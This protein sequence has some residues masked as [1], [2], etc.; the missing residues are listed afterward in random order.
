[1][2]KNH[3]PKPAN[4]PR[5]IALV[6]DD[7]IQLQLWK[8]LLTRQGYIVQDYASATLALKEFVDSSQAPDLIIS[9]LHM[10]VID[11]WRFC[12]LLRSPGLRALN[13]VPI[14]MVSATYDGDEIRHLCAASGANAF[15][16]SPVDGE[17]FLKQ[18]K[19]LLKNNSPSATEHILIALTDHSQSTR[20][21]HT[22]QLAGFLVTIAHS[23]ESIHKIYSDQPPDLLVLDTSFL[24][25]DDPGLQTLINQRSHPLVILSPPEQQPDTLLNWLDLGVAAW[26]S[27][28]IE[29]ERLAVLCANLLREQDLLDIQETLK[30]RTRQL[31]ISETRFQLTTERFNMATAPTGIG[32][33]DLD[34]RKNELIWDERMF[35]LYQVDPIEFD[36]TY[37]SWQKTVYPD[38]LAKICPVIM[39]AALSLQD[40]ESDFRILWQN[41]E[42]RYIK[43]FGH[44]VLDE[45]G[46]TKRMTGINFDIT[47]QKQAEEALRQREALLDATQRLTHIGGWEYH[48]IDQAM[49]WTDE[50]YRIHGLDIDEIEPGS[51]RHI[52]QSLHCYDPDDRPIILA[53]FQRCV[54]EGTPYDLEFP[55][56][57]FIGRHK[58]IRTTAEAIYED[59]KITRV[60]GNIMDI[61]ERKQAE[62][63][64][65]LHSLVLN[66]IQDCVTIT[67]LEGN[68]TYVNQAEQRL[69]KRDAKDLIGHNVESYG[70]D[71]ERGATQRQIIDQ[72]LAHGKWR[73]EVV[74]YAT[75]GSEII[76]DARTQ[77]VQDTH[78]KPL[79]LCGVSTDITERKRDEARL[80]TTLAE[81]ETL[82]QELYHRTKNNM[83]LIS[84]M[85][86]LQAEANPDLSANELAE[87]ITKKIRAMALVH[88]K[89]YQSQDL[90]IID[91]GNYVQ[92]FV[93][94][95]KDSYL[96]YPSRI[97]LLTDVESILVTIDTAIPC[98]LILNEL[99]TNALKYAFPGEKSGEIKIRLRQ[100]EP[101]MIELQVA[102]NGI[103]LPTNFDL[104]AQKTLGMQI[105]TGIAKIQLAGEINFESNNGLCCTFRFQDNLYPRRV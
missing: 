39:D 18:V 75:D 92:D 49:Y 53:A 13:Q 11:G 67:D 27:T 82:L 104:N 3:K 60:I 73:G 17:I 14:L 50:V 85:L 10:P 72:T 32:I 74:N 12:R 2:S 79:A 41:G 21:Q 9:D 22:L 42:I 57:T 65:R 99:T 46:Q 30:N 47:E 40:F 78:G 43:V 91:L 102:D 96:L 7:P 44:I 68:I 69:L 36:G 54:N 95:I 83:E 70:E 66:Q 59:N 77:V 76:M 29:G 56:T 80:R 37:Q 6:N 62:E 71:P 88:Q 87:N 55:F 16:P 103:G 51:T 48:V 24:A 38:D 98:G 31:S 105:I 23:P 61:T 1:V 33:W 86:H 89:L 8:G 15:L 45:T 94:L 58:W 100:Y 63:R 35:E 20:F 26:L 101:A 97:T 25:Y 28:T 84:S 93:E 90:S 4:L 64:I 34:L 19:D 52:Q 81:K 5:S